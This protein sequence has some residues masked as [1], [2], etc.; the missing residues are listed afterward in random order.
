MH[1][2][3]LGPESRKL[4]MISIQIVGSAHFDSVEGSKESRYLR[5]SVWSVCRY[6]MNI[7][8]RT[9]QCERIVSCQSCFKCIFFAT[10]MQRE[11]RKMS[12]DEI[13]II[14]SVALHPRYFLNMFLEDL[15]KS[16]L[17]NCSVIWIEGCEISE[18]RLFLLKRSV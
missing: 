5:C 3:N 8:Y 7:S 14:R 17:R 18:S 4:E 16:Y 12:K 1:C 13:A 11:L 6:K 15:L 2:F 10:L 9:E